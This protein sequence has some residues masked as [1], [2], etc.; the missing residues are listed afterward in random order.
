MTPPV[1]SRGWCTRTG[2]S[3]TSSS[4]SPAVGCWSPAPSGYAL[5]VKNLYTMNVEYYTG[6][7]ERLEVPMILPPTPELV[8]VDRGPGAGCRRRRR[9]GSHP[10]PGQGVLPRESVR[11]ALRGALR[12]AA[13]GGEVRVR[14]ARDRPWI[15]FPWSDPRTPS[16]S[17]CI[18]AGED[19]AIKLRRITRAVLRPPRPT[20]RRRGRWPRR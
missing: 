10:G 17:R 3:P 14:V 2:S 18:S 13:L 8:D 6:V 19:A 11:G 16:P 1:I 12:E 15:K 5:T 20:P 4:P 9:H 7:D